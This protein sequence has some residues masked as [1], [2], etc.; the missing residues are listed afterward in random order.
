MDLALPKLMECFA[1]FAETA[2]CRVTTFTLYVPPA[3]DAQL[4]RSM[5]RC[6]PNLEQLVLRVAADPASCTHS[7]IELASVTDALPCLVECKSLRALQLWVSAGHVRVHQLNKALNALRL[8][9][10]N[11]VVGVT[12]VR[13]VPG[14]VS[15]L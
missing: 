11:V 1:A 6:M 5:I 8:R 14:G 13:T 7:R 10:K 3:F 12:V 2:V 15:H 9:L 4:I